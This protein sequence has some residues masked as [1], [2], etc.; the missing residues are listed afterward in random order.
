MGS[1]APKQSRG[2]SR[3]KRRR[4]GFLNLFGFSGD[5]YEAEG[6]DD[7][8]SESS[9]HTRSERSG[10]RSSSETDGRD[11]G[12]CD[13]TAQPPDAPSEPAEDK[14]ASMRDANAVI[15]SSGGVAGKGDSVTTDVSVSAR[16]INFG[17]QS[18]S[19]EH[20]AAY[21]D[22]SGPGHFAA[23]TPTRRQGLADGTQIRTCP[24]PERLRLQLKE[25]ASGLGDSGSPTS[26]SASTATESPRMIPEAKARRRGTIG[27]FSGVAVDAR[28]MGPDKQHSPRVEKMP[29]SL[30]RRTSSNNST[31]STATPTS[32]LST[33][34]SASATVTSQAD[35]S[36]LPDWEP[37]SQQSSAKARGRSRRY[38]V[39]D[40]SFANQQ[41]QR[42]SGGL[43]APY[44]AGQS[45]ISPTA[46]RRGSSK[47]TLDIPA[48]PDSQGRLGGADPGFIFGNIRRRTSSRMRAGSPPADMRGAY[49]YAQ[50]SPTLAHSGYSD[51]PGSLQ[52]RRRQSRGSITTIS[53][54]SQ[55]TDEMQP[56]SDV[57][58]PASEHSVDSGSRRCR[59]RS[60]V[61]DSSSGQSTPTGL[62]F[63]R[64]HRNRSSSVKSANIAEISRSLEPPASTRPSRRPNESPC[65]RHSQKC[66]CGL[67]NKPDMDRAL[68]LDSDSAIDAQYLKFAT[69]TPDILFMPM[70][71]R[72]GGQT[73]TVKR[74]DYSYER[75]LATSR[76]TKAHRWRRHHPQ[77]H[78]D[79]AK[80]SL[81]Y[82][83]RRSTSAFAGGQ[84][85]SQSRWNSAQRPDADMAAESPT[86][87]AIFRPT[88]DLGDEVAWD[89]WVESVKG[90]VHAGVV[91]RAVDMW[92]RIMHN[93]KRNHMKLGSTVHRRDSSASVLGSPR[94]PE[95]AR[96]PSAV[97]SVETGTSAMLNPYMV[98]PTYLLRGVSESGRHSLPGGDFSLMHQLTGYS[99]MDSLL[100][101]PDPVPAST[102]HQSVAADAEV[103]S[104]QQPARQRISGHSLLSGAAPHRRLSIVKSQELGHALVGK[105]SSAA[106]RD[107]SDDGAISTNTDASQA[108]A[109]KGP[110]LIARLDDTSEAVNVLLSFQARMQVR[111]SRAKSESEEELLA[112]IQSLGEFVEEG[113]SYVHEDMDGY[114]AA[115]VDSAASD[116]EFSDELYD[117]DDE[118]TETPGLVMPGRLLN[119]EH[120]RAVQGMRGS[121]VQS[122]LGPPTWASEA[123]STQMELKSLNQRLHDVLN[124]HAGD[125]GVVG[126]EAACSDATRREP[127]PA[128]ETVQRSG[129]PS[130]LPMRLPRSPSIRRLAFLRAISGEGASA[131]HAVE[132][133][134]ETGGSVSSHED[135]P[136]IVCTPSA[137]DTES[138]SGRPRTWHPAQSGAGEYFDGWETGVA[139]Q[140]SGLASQPGAV[141]FPGLHKRRSTQSVRSGKSSGAGSRH[142][143]ADCSASRTSL[144]SSGS[145][146]S[147]LTTPLIAEDEFKPTPFLEA[148]MDLVNIIGLVLALTP[149]DMLRPLSGALL[150]E[151]L[152]N[153]DAGD[154]ERV[155][156]LMPTEF[157]V[158][159]LDDLGRR[160][161]QAQV[162]GESTADHAWPCRGLFFRA[163][164]AISSLNRIVMWYVAVR[165]VYSD[166]VVA[167]LDRRVEARQLDKSQAQAHVADRDRMLVSSPEPYQHMDVATPRSI[168]QDSGGI[169]ESLASTDT[170]GIPGIYGSQHDSVNDTNHENSPGAQSWH[171]YHVDHA[172]R[173][174]E[175]QGSIDSATA[176]DKGL[177]ML[178]EISLE[179]RIRYISP[180]CQQLLGADPD[181][182]VDQPAT[183]MFDSRDV[184]L[185]RSAVEQL[186]ADSTRTVEL[187]VRVHPPDGSRSVRVEAKGMLIYTRATN[188]P[189]HVLWVLRYL[190]SEQSSPLDE[191][192]AEPARDLSDVPC[193]HAA[194][195][196]GEVLVLPSPMEPIT[197][198]ICDRSIP[199]TYFEEHSWLCA[200]SH[201]A[202]MDVERQNE[203][204]D[205]IKSQLLAWHPGC[206]ADELESVLHGDVD[207]LRAL[208]QQRAD[209]VGNAVW[210]QLVAAAD[211]AVQSMVRT[212]AQ[213]MCIKRDDAAPQCAWTP[214]G[215]SGAKGDSDFSR[216][217]AWV[218]VA[219]YTLPALHDPCLQALG[220]SLLQTIGAKLAA[221]DDLQYAI[222]DSVLACTKWMRIEDSII[223]PDS[224]LDFGAATRPAARSTS[225]LVGLVGS[226][227]D[228]A[229]RRWSTAETGSTELGAV[230]VRPAAAGF[231]NFNR[232][233]TKEGGGSRP[234]MLLRKSQSSCSMAVQST[235]PASVAASNVS[236]A[237][238]DSESSMSATPGSLLQVS[239]TNL[240]PARSPGRAHLADDELMATPTVPSIHDFDLLK[241]ISKGA[242][243]SVY[244]A[245]K[246]STGTYYA[247]KILK[248]ADMI[249]KNQ[250]SNVKAERAIMMAQT[251][252]PF[253]VRLLYTFQSRS[254]LYLVMEYLNGGDCAALLKAIGV[255]PEEWARQYLA[256]VV[257]GI[258][259]LHSRNVVHRDLKPDNLLIDSEGH[260]KLTDFGLSKLGFL[261]RRV[262]QQQP[263]PGTASCA[264][265]KPELPGIPVSMPPVR[266]DGGCRDSAIDGDMDVEGQI[267]A[268]KRVAALRNDGSPQLS[269]SVASNSSASFSSSAD[270]DAS[271]ATP[272]SPRRKHAL[273]TP[274]YIAPESIL[275]LE[276]GESVDWW[277]LGVIC[278]ELLF[279]IPPFHDTTPERVFQNI[280]AGKIDFYDDE[281]QA[282]QHK[283]DDGDDEDDEA[284]PEISAEA[285]DFIMRLL[286]RDPKRRLGYRGAAEVKAHPLFRGIDW[287]SLLDVQPAFVPQVESIED[288]DYFDTRGATMEHHSD[289][290]QDSDASQ[291]SDTSQHKR[292]STPG[293]EN[294]ESD[295]DSAAML[296]KS[297]GDESLMPKPAG[298]AIRRPQTLPVRLNEM[299]ERADSVDD[300]GD[301]GGNKSTR[302]AARRGSGQRDESLPKLDEETEFGG[303]TFKNLHVLE[304]AN[305]NELVK[306][307]RR[308][309]LM[310]ARPSMPLVRPIR[311]LMGGSGSNRSSVTSLSS[312][313]SPAFRASFGAQQGLSH[314]SGIGPPLVRTATLPLLTTDM[315][316]SSSESASNTLAAS[317]ALPTHSRALSTHSQRG[318]LLNPN[319]QTP[320]SADALSADALSFAADSQHDIRQA[321]VGRLAP[322]PPT[323]RKSVTVGSLSR[324]GSGLHADLDRPDRAFHTDLNRSGHTFDTDNGLHSGQ[325]GVC[326]VADDNPVCC[327]IM[328][329]I[330]QRMHIECLVVRNGA[331]AIRSAMGRTAYRAIFMDT[332]MPI[333]DGDEATR[334]IK[335]TY[336]SNK[337]TPVFAMAAYEDEANRVLY[338]G[339]LV[340]PITS[341]QIE[342]LLG[343]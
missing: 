18:I 115:E 270:D 27:A 79:K 72:V 30:A 90:P 279:G 256:E 316:A 197:C 13:S 308:S 104:G 237:Y 42:P 331:E 191:E 263:I 163:L 101:S 68:D 339:V 37:A 55:P 296:S 228:L 201:R 38:S 277:A 162:P 264:Q 8:S 147:L 11:H 180:T 96:T 223:V 59:Q 305:M 190:A 252:S 259:D 44:N 36:T 315:H 41:Q 56:E 47:S 155:R 160:W 65:L 153:A 243:G 222:V 74:P 22:S 136:C 240:T 284:V 9:N 271:S 179:G 273:G 268:N 132:R 169:S 329:I 182:L 3:Q 267:A 272:Q 342:Q 314:G 199:A 218:A 196:A 265:Q 97:G 189:S 62:L 287:D 70:M 116:D 200:K 103:T 248:K 275:G 327:K 171:N 149:E 207:G 34:D 278:Y 112:I 49:S 338:D 145:G 326:L 128:I 321:E 203:R 298:I 336:N 6:N 142:S 313:L 12:L 187:E 93:W 236:S 99:Q 310:G 185:C 343:L 244:L 192:V 251:G 35:A 309:T 208:A 266:G 73:R 332:R 135:A 15:S 2:R 86:R 261:G 254:N 154:D 210:Q 51:Y 105:P 269:F 233:D 130:P 16:P 221:V 212:C 202:A 213:A 48:E 335:S 288:T 94:L 137:S 80:L 258:E 98:E 126:A 164:L 157:L 54:H 341:S 60:A 75:L 4:F 177:N 166:D 176:L 63:S 129:L 43:Q 28:H 193:T 161:E 53:M 230:Q 198:R 123:A 260:L 158:Q 174:R 89:S 148:I 205:D 214:D 181:V 255:L 276:S 133:P 66:P 172:P 206:S 318:S 78:G 100:G 262:G 302:K 317:G 118:G 306:L 235:E 91:H 40:L 61:H 85:S 150:D 1:T 159:R 17:R 253:V 289:A 52:S 33:A 283:V 204:L 119:A 131:A 57:Q 219:E 14:G 246:R 291:N 117:T 322:P 216:S 146:T 225:D 139:G 87:K 81:P 299:P 121:G 301:K 330:L 307:R 111:L 241:P 109:D 82:V 64:M 114:E 325:S 127:P 304:E 319:V 290:S 194:E 226:Q 188:E 186:L 122:R 337:D 32:A 217:D 134:G 175:S 257:L 282:M 300:A 334:M 26:L 209:S 281:R 29:I 320:Q 46:R 242:Y 324:P 227:T 312:D 340:K 247:I 295:N 58:T 110:W 144:Y 107:R 69:S 125:Q 67:C 5:A 333:V 173:W 77:N 323:F 234:P 138:G 292:G 229:Q 88:Q 285:R 140:Q 92:H 280:L 238:R 106:A 250:I 152:S 249:A 25:Q 108:S 274:D 95:A 297:H 328:E 19:N 20:A 141:P 143:V 50:M 211:P 231:E 39:F 245:K 156:L 24:I 83:R 167:E 293:S 102:T 168:F 113:L 294:S 195:G 120:R 84:P 184:E 239:T 7:G 183:A 21:A 170:S 71:L 45:P 178:V 224:V 31:W 124:R 286:C 220:R 151:A 23:I 215:K 303:F 76:N 232:A 10:S 165:A 311:S